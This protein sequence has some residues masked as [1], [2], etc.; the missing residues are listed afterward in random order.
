MKIEFLNILYF[1]N[2]EKGRKE[3]RKK[4]EIKGKKKDYPFNL[5]TQS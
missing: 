3:E 5:N 4:E 2:K 1:Y